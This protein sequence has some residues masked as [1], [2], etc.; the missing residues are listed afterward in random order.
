VL[1]AI[2]AGLLLYSMLIIMVMIMMLMLLM[3]MMLMMIMMVKMTV[4]LTIVGGLVAVTAG[5]FGSMEFHKMKK[6]GI[7]VSFL[8]FYLGIAAMSIV[9]IW[10]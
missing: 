4:M 1:E 8:A 10:A 2:A 7:F 3:I 6:V 9:G 5:E